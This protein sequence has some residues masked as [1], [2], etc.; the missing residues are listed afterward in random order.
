MCI[1]GNECPK[2][3]RYEETVHYLTTTWNCCSWV[4]QV[5]VLK[6]L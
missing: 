1:T 4:S 3:A 2:N 5:H 6:K